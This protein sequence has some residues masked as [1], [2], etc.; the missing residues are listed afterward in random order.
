M[1]FSVQ[2]AN[3]YLLDQ[4]LIIGNENIGPTGPQGPTGPAQTTDSITAL[5]NLTS[6][7]NFNFPDTQWERLSNINQNL[8][9]T[10]DATFDSCNLT[11]IKSIANP[12]LINFDGGNNTTES[13][14]VE[15]FGNGF[16]QG[17]LPP[18]LNVNGNIGVGLGNDTIEVK[19]RGIVIKAGQ[20]QG[21]ATLFNVTTNTEDSI[22]NINQTE[23]SSNYGTSTTGTD[24]FAFKTVSENRFVFGLQSDEKGGNSGSNFYL[25]SHSDNGSILAK[26]IQITRSNNQVILEG[27]LSLL[28]ISDNTNGNITSGT[29]T[30]NF[31]DFVGLTLVTSLGTCKYQ[32][33]GNIVNVRGVIQVEGVAPFSRG[34][35]FNLT[36]PYINNNF[37]T[38]FECSG[39]GNGYNLGFWTVNQVE[40]TKLSQVY[41]L[42][43]IDITDDIIFLSFSYEIN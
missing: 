30:P 15:L 39:T 8:T 29:Y 24:H 20:D 17:I 38:I 28:T 37:T 2:S 35:S 32:R 4:I 13:Q 21:S 3:S 22:F 16:Q 26:P 9:T 7:Q 33:I 11:Q 31:S 23:T 40:N 6:V 19:T 27:P 42:N 34:T 14:N 1:S 36:M 25:S 5:P 12:L 43:N 10:S 18:S 41:L